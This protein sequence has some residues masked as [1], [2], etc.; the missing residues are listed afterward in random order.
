MIQRR[1]PAFTSLVAIDPVVWQARAMLL[2]AFG[3][4]HAPD[5]VQSGRNA[6]ELAVHR[7]K[8]DICR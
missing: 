8:K 4:T 6:P 7:A 5:R 2:N 3:K 1:S